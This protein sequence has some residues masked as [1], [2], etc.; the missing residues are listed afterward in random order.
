VDVGGVWMGGG[1]AARKVFDLKLDQLG[2]YAMRYSRNGKFLSFSLL[3]TWEHG[4][5]SE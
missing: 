2:P 1:Q 4:Y 5:H 3:I